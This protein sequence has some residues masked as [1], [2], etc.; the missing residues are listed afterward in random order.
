MIFI[1][2]ILSHQKFIQNKNFYNFRILFFFS[3][4]LIWINGEYISI[5]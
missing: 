5:K 2:D 4:S 3:L 1:L